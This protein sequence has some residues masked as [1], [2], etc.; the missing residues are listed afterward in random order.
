[1]RSRVPVAIAFVFAVG[2]FICLAALSYWNPAL[3]FYAVLAWTTL[4]ILATPVVGWALAIFAMPFQNLFALSSDGFGRIRAILLFLLTVWALSLAVRRRT[5]RSP[6]LWI[7]LAFAVL[8]SLHEGV[9][10]LSTRHLVRDILFSDTV[11]FLALGAVYIISREFGGHAGGMA[12]AQK[13]M[14]LSALVCGAFSFLFL[15]LPLPGLIY[16]HQ[17]LDNLRLV[18]V[19]DN[20]NALAKLLLPSLLFLVCWA[21]F[22]PRTSRLA[23]PLIFVTTFLLAATD[24][25]SVLV[26]IVTTLLFLPPFLRRPDA[27]LQGFRSLVLCTVALLGF[28]TWLLGAAPWVERHAARQWIARGEWNLCYYLKVH[29]SD[30]DDCESKVSTANDGVVDV[31]GFMKNAV[32]RDLR[33]QASFV[34]S[35]AGKKTKYERRAFSPYQMGQR[36]RTWGGGLKIVEQYWLWGIGGPAQWSRH[37]QQILGYPFDSPHSALLEVTGSYGVLGLLLYLAVIGLFVQNYLAM[38]KWVRE[39][40][41]RIANEWTFLCGVAVFAVETIEVLTVFGITIHAIWFWV[42]VGLQAGLRDA[43]LPVSQGAKSGVAILQL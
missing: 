13:A 43:V 5:Y 37:M 12:L 31:V 23:I 42:I 35:E 21:I 14:L 20:P 41:Q 2:G 8:V 18:G 11:F 1:M 33:L 3:A 10:S 28:A 36:D 25:R 34:M 32:T 29:S 15:Y 4:V 27:Q 26:G 6:M 22:Q 7:L 30:R 40:W 24:T 16:F 39:P 17:E 9:S 38:R 19:Q